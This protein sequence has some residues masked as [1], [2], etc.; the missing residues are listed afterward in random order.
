MIFNSNWFYNRTEDK[1]MSFDDIVSIAH[2]VNEDEFISYIESSNYAPVTEG[3]AREF[4]RD[5]CGTLHTNG[6]S[7]IMSAKGIA[8][9]MGITE[10]KAL[11]YLY[12]CAELGITE[13]Q[14][15][16]WVI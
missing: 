1:I 7:G 6:S 13:K 3:M 4:C 8:D 2:C 12:T 14:N 15:G 9:R 10:N 16:G 11:C 5:L